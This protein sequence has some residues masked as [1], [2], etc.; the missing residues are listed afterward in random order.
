MHK[1]DLFSFSNNSLL[2]WLPYIMNLVRAALSHHTASA[3]DICTLINIKQE[4][5]AHNATS[6]NTTVVVSLLLGFF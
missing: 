6:S 3:G 1:S 5:I 4:S 2:T